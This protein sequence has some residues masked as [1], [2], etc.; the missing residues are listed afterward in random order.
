MSSSVNPLLTIDAVRFGYLGQPSVVNGVSLELTAGA[1]HCLIGRSGCGKSTLLK[2]CAGLHRPQSGQVIF[3]NETI[4]EPAQAMGFVFQSPTLLSWLNVL[5]NV[6]LPVSLHSPINS[7]DRLRAMQLLESMGLSGLESRSPLQ[8]SGGQQSRVAIA[9]ALIT[10]PKI[11]FMDE[12]FTALDAITREELHK[13]FLSLCQR[14]QIAVLF[15]TH[16]IAEAVYLG[17]FVSVMHSGNL[18]TQRVVNLA[19]PRHPT[20]RYSPDF[21]MLCAELRQAM[22]HHPEPVL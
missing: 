14:Q 1:I 16:D 22:E 20:I 8:L 15:V 4:S 2:I 21:N 6:L 5:D 18:K 17:D 12:P 19:H 9:R 7:G 11:L 3:N 13:D 10:N